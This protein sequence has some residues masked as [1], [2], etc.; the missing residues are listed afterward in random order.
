ML[1]QDQLRQLKEQ[2]EGFR[3]M[4]ERQRVKILQLEASNT[5]VVVIGPDQKLVM[6]EDAALQPYLDAIELEGDM[7]ANDA[8]AGGDDGDAMAT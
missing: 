4:E 3:I 1:T 6:I 2:E 5:C 7:P 8:G